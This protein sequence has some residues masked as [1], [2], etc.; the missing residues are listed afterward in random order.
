MTTVDEVIWVYGGGPRMGE[1]VKG[2]EPVGNVGWVEEEE[3]V[4][5]IEMEL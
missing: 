3:K 2:E 1:E 5:G 4:D